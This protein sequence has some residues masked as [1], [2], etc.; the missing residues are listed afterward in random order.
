MSEKKIFYCVLNEYILLYKNVIFVPS[1][2]NGRQ[3]FIY[4]RLD[5]V[6]NKVAMAHGQSRFLLWALWALIIGFYNIASRN[7][8]NTDREGML[9]NREEKEERKKPY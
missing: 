6:Y 1:P 4:N 3:G 7:Y 2:L 5:T 8:Y 9:R